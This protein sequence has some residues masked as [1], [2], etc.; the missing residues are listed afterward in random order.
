MYFCWENF[1]LASQQHASKAGLENPRKQR[2]RDPGAIRP[3]M[4]CQLRAIYTRQ[5]VAKLLIPKK[6]ARNERSLNVRK[7]KMLQ[8]GEV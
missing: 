7:S 4:A 1:V 3:A 6:D 8:G 5:L 2:N